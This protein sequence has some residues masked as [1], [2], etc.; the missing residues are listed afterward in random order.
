MQIETIKSFLPH[1]LVRTISWLIHPK[2]NWLRIKKEKK[3]IK[4]IEEQPNLHKKAL[5][6]IK[7][8]AVYNCVFFA[9]YD[10]NWKYDRVYQIMEQNPLFNPMILVCPVVNYGKE[11]MLETMNNSYNS[12]MR[13]GYRVLKSYD[14]T[15]DTY[16]NVKETLRPDIILYTNP[17]KGLIDDRYY[18]DQYPNIL[19]IYV[20]YGFNSTKPTPM[21]YN[22]PMHNLSWRYYA[23]TVYHIDDRHVRDSSRCRG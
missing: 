15:T 14:E 12:F 18:I 23:E 2:K 22:Q 19:S 17:Y 5:L 7:D 6:K 3:Y 10:S 13:K 20:P 4:I 1:S 8:K 9:I 11:H 21:F 16:I